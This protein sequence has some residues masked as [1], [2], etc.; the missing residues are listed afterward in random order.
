MNIEE[1]IRIK[2]FNYLEYCDYLQ[3]K[4]G[5]GLADYFTKSWNKNQKVTRTNDGL[6]AHHKF[7]DHAIMLSNKDYAQKNPF[8]WQKKENIVY[9]DYLEHL[10]LHILICENPSD[11]KNL[12]EAVGVGGVINFIV[13]ELNDVYS[14]FKTKQLWRKNLHDKIID[15]KDVYMLLIKRFK[16]FCKRYGLEE[17][18]AGEHLLSSFNEKFGL[19]EREKNTKI[20]EE[21]V[22]I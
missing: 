4:Y 22:R 10:L 5:I 9:C 20:F 1:Y 6:V 3:K 16:N 21:I 14:G 12:L 2:E 13:P 8:E 18:F 17:I 7:E 11:E 19:W 15:D